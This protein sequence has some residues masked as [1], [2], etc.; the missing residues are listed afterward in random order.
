MGTDRVRRACLIVTMMVVAGCPAPVQ[1]PPE[2]TAPPP[3]VRDPDA[4]VAE[5]ALNVGERAPD[6][7]LPVAAGGSWSLAQGLEKGRVVIVFYRGHWCPYCRTQLGQLQDTLDEFTSRGIKLVTISRDDPADSLELSSRLEITLPMLSDPDL[8][9]IN[10]YWVKDP[11]NEFA[12]PSIFIVDTEGTIV[13][14]S[15]AEHFKE[16]PTPEVIL[17]ALDNLDRPPEPPSK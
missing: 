2:V 8:A 9:V 1:P 7:S 15:I 4:P 16:R 6:F 11:D 5:R 17:E 14:R 13:W 10:Q 12:W 3:K